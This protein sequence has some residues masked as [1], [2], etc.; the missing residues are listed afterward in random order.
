[1]KLNEDDC[2]I[3]DKNDKMND[4]YMAKVKTKYPSAGG[5][6]LGQGGK[7]AKKR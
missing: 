5:R 3:L 2:M 6:Q 7:V 4:D 1:M